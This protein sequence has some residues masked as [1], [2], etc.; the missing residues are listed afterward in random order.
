MKLVGETGI[1][2]FQYR[3]NTLKIWGP[4]I[5]EIAIYR[6]TNSSDTFRLLFL[7]IMVILLS[8]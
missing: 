2:Y 5:H 7:E 6:K 3:P 1:R 8:A 4:G